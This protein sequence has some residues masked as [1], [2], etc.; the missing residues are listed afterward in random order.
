MV[1]QSL[2]GRQLSRSDVFTFLDN[3]LAKRKR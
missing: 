1:R 2:R 3:K